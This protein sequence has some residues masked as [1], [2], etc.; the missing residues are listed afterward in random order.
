MASSNSNITGV[1]ISLIVFVMLTLILAVLSFVEFRDLS[2][3]Q[4]S[5]DK[6]KAD[7]AIAE[8]A[9]SNLDDEV[10]A[11]KEKIGH[12]DE[13]VGVGEPGADTVLGKS[14]ADLQNVAQPGATQASYAPALNDLRNRLETQ[15][16]E[17]NKNQQ[18]INDEQ[19]ERAR[20]RSEFDGKLKVAQDAQ[21]A[22]EAGR[23]KDAADQQEIRKQINDELA[24]VDAKYRRLQSDYQQ[25]K[26]TWDNEKKQLDYDLTLLTSANDRLWD[27]INRI[28]KVSFEKP[29]GL[30]NTV[31]HSSGLVWINLGSEDNL[32]KRLTFSV[33]NRAHHG[34][35][36]GLDDLKGAIEVTRVLGPHLAQARILGR[37]SF[38][39]ITQNDP[40]YTP[41]WS[42]GRVESFAFVGILDFDNDG[43]SDR[44]RMKELVAASGAKITTEVDDEGNRTGKTIGV[45]TKYLVVGELPDPA[46][47]ADAEKRANQFQVLEHFTDMEKEARIQGVR[48]ISLSDFLSHIG[49]KPKRRFWAPG[50]QIPWRLKGGAQS[51]S[52]NQTLGNRASS[53]QVSGAYGK[54]LLTPKTSSGQT[55]KI[56][57][58]ARGGY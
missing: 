17:A 4:T 33:Y 27:E 16:Q 44:A 14:S 50:M 52:V 41:L 45:E 39:P 49:Y 43:L 40:I 25:D 31:D 51:S 34:V 36:R 15:T 9:N 57:R 38:N 56:F 55:S 48:K 29:D 12:M 54:R 10:Q 6:A 24:A 37:D 30:I 5:L 19:A 23:A 22:A 42:P 58:G 1:H 21:K 7:Q 2:T 8:K 13:N 47:E 26:E 20:Q 11:L 32:P 46:E 28:T 35:G 53:G 3:K 18:I